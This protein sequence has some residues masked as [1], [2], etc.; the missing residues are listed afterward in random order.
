MSAAP[1]NYFPTFEIAVLQSLGEAGAQGQRDVVIKVESGKEDLNENV[2]SITIP[3]INEVNLSMK[4]TG[5][6]IYQDNSELGLKTLSGDIFIVAKKN[7]QQEE[8]LYKIHSPVVPISPLNAKDNTYP[9]IKDSKQFIERA[10]FSAFGE[11]LSDIIDQTTVITGN[12]AAFNPYDLSSSES[13]NMVNPKHSKKEVKSGFKLPY[14]GGV[15]LIAVV[16]FCI[17]LVGLKFINNSSS[18]QQQSDQQQVTTTGG[19]QQIPYDE[20]NDV[21]NQGSFAPV[22]QSSGESS[23]QNSEQQIE[24]EVLDEFGLESNVSL[25]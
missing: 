17:V 2:Q 9:P 19:I 23:Q 22:P 25:D 7:N 24:A 4:L 15:A 12:Q 21:S 3:S 16:V 5:F 20:S 14:W 8:Q 18:E 11:A 1:H 13:E 10:W 6:D